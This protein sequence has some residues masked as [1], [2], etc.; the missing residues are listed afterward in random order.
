MG[1]GIP[2]M[3]N[4]LSVEAVDLAIGADL[5]KCSGPGS[6]SPRRYTGCSIIC[7]VHSLRHSA[8]LGLYLIHVRVDPIQLRPSFFDQA[9][10]LIFRRVCNEILAESLETGSVSH[11][12]GFPRPHRAK[13]LPYL[14]GGLCRIERRLPERELKPMNDLSCQRAARRPSHLLKAVLQLGRQPQVGLHVIGTH[15]AIMKQ[16]AC[17]QPSLKLHLTKH[18]AIYELH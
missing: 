1:K 6:A 4:K 10:K 11:K 8:Q 18:K 13:L 5:S 15:D 17:K 12:N 2:T 14:P 9:T 7:I 16:T 3:S